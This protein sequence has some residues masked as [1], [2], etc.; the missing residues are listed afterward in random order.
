MWDAMLAHGM[1]PGYWVRQVVESVLGRTVGHTRA[2]HPKNQQNCWSH[3]CQAPVKYISYVYLV[4]S[5]G[6]HPGVAVTGV[7]GTGAA[8]MVAGGRRD[9][10]P[11]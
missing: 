3:R 4:W 8:G 7:R 9:C 2:K 6:A 11:A 1:L 5:P 10:R